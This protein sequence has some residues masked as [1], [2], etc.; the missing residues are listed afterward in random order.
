MTDR[1]AARLAAFNTHADTYRLHCNSLETSGL[2]VALE[3]A[4]AAVDFADML[5]QA[6]AAAGD[7]AEAKRWEGNRDMW[8]KTS[9]HALRKYIDG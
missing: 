6:A 1:N 2:G 8:R 7:I 9:D 3:A 4:E 5:C